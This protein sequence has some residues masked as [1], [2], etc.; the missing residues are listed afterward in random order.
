MIRT[1]RNTLE[2]IQ[3]GIKDPNPEVRYTAWKSAMGITSAMGATTAAGMATKW[4]FNI[5]DDQDRA[6]RRLGMPWSED[7]TMLYTPIK[8]GETHILDLNYLAPHAFMAEGLAAI[9]RGDDW[10]EVAKTS[11]TSILG[12][13]VQGAPIAANFM[14]TAGSGV[15]P[16]EKS[17]GGLVKGAV[18]FGVNRNPYLENLRW[19][20]LPATVETLVRLST[21][22]S[23]SN[24]ELN[25]W[26]EAL[27]AFGLA[28]PVKIDVRESLK[29]KGFTYKEEMGLERRSASRARA[30]E[31]GSRFGILSV[32]DVEMEVEE[33]QQALMEDFAD[34]IRSAQDMGV[35]DWEIK[36]I[37]TR[38]I[39]DGG[40]G[41]SKK[42]VNAMFRMRGSAGDER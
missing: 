4:A 32:E 20:G 29:F 35:P 12:P 8:D 16:S 40:V 3:K 9:M 19:L 42:E 15:A 37:L 26:G 10:E 11:F 30:A 33:F 31:R 14:K 21:G 23:R 27:G 7:S 18:G 36:Q 24:R 39:K 1:T 22:R 5:S 17:L 28:K 6:I 41:M 13:F 38:P 25:R 2:F 34:V